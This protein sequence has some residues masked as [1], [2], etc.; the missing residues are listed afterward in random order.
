MKDTTASLAPDERAI[1]RLG[2]LVPQLA[3]VREADRGAAGA[4]KH[5]CWRRRMRSRI[6]GRMP[7]VLCSDADFA[8]RSVAAEIAAVWRVSDRTVQ[9][10]LGRCDHARQELSRDAGVAGGGEDLSVPSEDHR[11]R[12]R[13]DRTSGNA[14]GVRGFDPPLRRSR[15]RVTVD[16][17]RETSRRVV[18]RDHDRRAA[19]GGPC[20][21][22]GCGG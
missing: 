9:H 18:P 20:E 15:V 16:A 3:D 19:C 2:V 1:A 13:S 22:A 14:G 8:H 10:H 12:R 4:R 21:A 7:A 5:G 11:G 17:G 6:S